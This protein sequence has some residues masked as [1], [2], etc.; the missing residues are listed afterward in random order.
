MKRYILIALYVLCLALVLSTT[1]T[2]KGPNDG[3]E[4]ALAQRITETGWHPFETRDQGNTSIVI[5][6]IAPALSNLF[7][8]DVVWVFKIIFPLIFALCP[9][10]LFLLYRKLLLSH[11][12]AI[13][14]CLFFILLPPT[15]EQVPTIAKSM[16]AEP[17]AIV[18]LLVWFSDW[19]QRYKI[20]VLTVLIILTILSHYTVGFMLIGWLFILSI[21]QVR[22][23]ALIPIAVSSVFALAYFSFAAEGAVLYFVSHFNEFG[24][25]DFRTLLGL[26]MV[27]SNGVL[28]LNVQWDKYS[29]LYLLIISAG[30]SYLI[31][32]KFGNS[33]KAVMIVT[34]AA[35]ALA[36]FIPALT[37]VLFLSRWIQINAIVLAPLL[38]IGLRWLTKP[39]V[40]SL[41]A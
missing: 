8:L 27:Y 32:H 38:P 39:K 6:L 26:N 11:W 22:G 31:G 28:L 4:I 14:A 40:A 3:D 5:G 9:A 33:F 19:R 35:V 23:K 25:K 34:A 29:G 20:P 12:E 37:Y 1:L 2:F 30:A 21:K 17:L 41:H 7:H 16:V 36:Y 18:A 13:L 10:L 15:F 24:V